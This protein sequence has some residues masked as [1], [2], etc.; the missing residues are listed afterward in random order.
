M[1]IRFAYVADLE[2]FGKDDYW[3]TALE[4]LN[5]EHGD[6]E[7]WS[8]FAKQALLPKYQPVLLYVSY[9]KP[10]QQP[11][12]H[13]SCVYNR[14]VIDNT[15]HF[16]VKA[17]MSLAQIAPLIIKRLDKKAMLYKYYVWEV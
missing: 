16:R 13:I 17:Q 14:G 9:T 3:Q 12:A 4:M 5:R 6:C 10:H 8:I 2:Q 7:D 15:G 11:K 1:Q